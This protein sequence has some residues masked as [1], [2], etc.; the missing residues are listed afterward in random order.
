M[1]QD[2]PPSLQTHIHVYTH[3][4]ISIYKINRTKLTGKHIVPIFIILALEHHSIVDQDL[5]RPMYRRKELC[6]Y[7]FYNA[8]SK[9][10]CE[11]HIEKIKKTII[12]Q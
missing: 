6:T 7:I 5:H 1:P 8:V 3:K 2:H 11:N 4:H 9:N 12:M 10:E